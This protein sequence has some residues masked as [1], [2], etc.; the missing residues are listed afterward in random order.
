MSLPTFISRAF[1]IPGGGGPATAGIPPPETP[2]PVAAPVPPAPTPP[3]APT[4][5]QAPPSFAPTP[6][7]AAQRARIAS[8][9]PS[10]LGAAALAGQTAKAKAT[11]G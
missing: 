10:F 7:Q 11:L 5:A 2:A 3:P 6:T 8:G 4:A 9:T 1:T